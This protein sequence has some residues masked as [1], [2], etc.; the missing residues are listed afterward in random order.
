[1]KFF[2]GALALSTIAALGCNITPREA[3]FLTEGRIKGENP[4][5]AKFAIFG[6]VENAGR[7]NMILIATDDQGLCDKVGG[8]LTKFLEDI[9]TGQ[10]AGTHVLTVVDAPGAL[11]AGAQLA[12]DLDAGDF[13]SP[14]FLV[15][16]GSEL[17]VEA[18][19]RDGEGLVEIQEFDGQTL[20]GVVNVTLNRELSGF[21]NKKINV[22]MVGEVFAATECADI[23]AGLV[24]GGASEEEDD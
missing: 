18:I 19:D 11:A 10:I 12:G 1:M 5:N 13:V 6:A 15:A 4:K 16:N 17:Q 20:S 9:S 23:T 2:F 24:A 3:K 22:P 8:D 21:F 14:A 7:V